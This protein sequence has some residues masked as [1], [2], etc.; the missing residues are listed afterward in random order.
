MMKIVVKKG[1]W[2]GTS[3]KVLAL[4]SDTTVLVQLSNYKRMV[5]PRTS[6][7]VLPKEKT[8]P[9]GRFIGA[10]DFSNPYTSEED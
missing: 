2:E 1:I 3:G 10:L 5:L 7:E 6:V 4:T 8:A 9:I